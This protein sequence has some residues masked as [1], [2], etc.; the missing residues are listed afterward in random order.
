MDRVIQKSGRQIAEAWLSEVL[1]PIG[2]VYR[3]PAPDDASYPFIGISLISSVDLYG[4]GNPSTVE[5]LTYDV[6]AWDVGRSSVRVNEL[7]RRTRE[8]L[9]SIPATNRDGGVIL[10]CKRRGT[11]PIDQM[12][13][14][15]VTYQRDGGLFVIEVLIRDSSV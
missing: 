4:V 14:E 2:P 12:V 11:T 9:D 3:S 8:V 1:R 15:G 6:S 10:S 7:A 5:R 13:E